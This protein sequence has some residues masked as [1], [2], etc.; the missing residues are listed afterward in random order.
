VVGRQG[1]IIPK[2]KAHPSFTRCFEEVKKPGIC[3]DSWRRTGLPYSEMMDPRLNQYSGKFLF[4]KLKTVG[5]WKL[6][7]KFLV[8]KFH[9][10]QGRFKSFLHLTQCSSERSALNA[11]TFPW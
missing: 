2:F 6:R 10:L 7:V 8:A 5:A 11:K 9:H 3:G 1:S 4:L